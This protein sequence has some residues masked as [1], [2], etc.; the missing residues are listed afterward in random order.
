MGLPLPTTTL[1][2]TVGLAYARN[3][4]AYNEDGTIPT[5]WLNTDTLAATLSPGQGLASLFAPTV[6]WFNA[7]QGQVSLSMTGTQTAMVSPDAVYWLEIQGTR[8][9][10][11]YPLAWM[12]CQFLPAAGSQAVA[13]PPDLITLPYANR[14][15]SALVLTPSQF[16]MIPTLIT[17]SSAAWRKW[18]N[19]RF[20]KQTTSAVDQINVQVCEVELD[21]S[22]RLDE[23]P[24]NYIQRIQTNPTEAMVASNNTAA[25]AWC[26]AATTGDVASGQAITGLVLN[27]ESGGALNSTTI[28]FAANETISSLASAISAAGSGWTA[29]ADSVLG[30]WSVAEL[31]DLL[32][33]QGASPNDQPNGYAS[34]N[35]YASNCTNIWFHPDDGQKTGI[36]FVGRQTDDLGVK[37]GPTWGDIISVQPVKGRVLATYNGGY[38]TVPFEVQLGCLE[39]VKACLER[40][41]SELIL[42]DEKGIDYAYTLI[43]QPGAIPDHVRQQMALYKVTNA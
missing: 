32:A 39:L 30:A 31:I 26:Y 10:T 35:V 28:T 29:T 20:T 19:R 34:Y 6:T 36:V 37:W 2:P 40:L 23:I 33:S 9:G 1:N 41:K 4:Q 8:S 15:L 24:V 22:I 38:A 18:C 13:S 5:I 43:D 16:E 27:W 12:W 3:I 11:T 17:A 7:G 42:K 21:G 25:T 14:L